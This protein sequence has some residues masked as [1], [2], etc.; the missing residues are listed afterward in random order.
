MQITKDQTIAG[1]PAI[2]VRNF[3][4]R[5]S[6]MFW[7]SVAEE[8]LENGGAV[9]DELLATG[10][11]EA[12]YV[13]AEGDTRLGMTTQGFALRM[14]SAAKPVTR[15][16]AQ[17]SVDEVVARALVVNADPRAWATVRRLVLFGSFMDESV[18]RV[19]D[20]D[21]AVDAVCYEPHP[22]TQQGARGYYRM[23]HGG[24]PG[25]DDRLYRWD[26]MRMLKGGSRVLSLVEFEQH[27]EMLDAVPTRV[28][29]EA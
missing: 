20:V 10:R 11:V 15:A 17:R 6:E 26:V 4:R 19:G 23:V 9:V 1:V 7:R 13:D 27:R 25:P 14:A 12:L 28:I 24:K 3:L 21:I 18:D 16:T 22:T 2:T 5:W 29:F 8:Q